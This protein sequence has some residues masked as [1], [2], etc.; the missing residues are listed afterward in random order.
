MSRK[1]P[2]TRVPYPRLD[3]P[4]RYL[5]SLPVRVRVAKSM[6]MA[7]RLDDLRARAANIRNQSVSELVGDGFTYA[8]IASLL[9]VSESRV[10]QYLK[11]SDSPRVHKTTEQRLT[12]AQAAQVLNSYNPFSGHKDLHLSNFGQS[13][14]ESIVAGDSATL[15]ELITTLYPLWNVEEET[16]DDLQHYRDTLVPSVA[17]LGIVLRGCT[18]PI[19]RAGLEPVQQSLLPGNTVTQ[20]FLE[21][22]RPES[23]EKSF[24]LFS[25]APIGRKEKKREASEREWFSSALLFEN[26]R[27]LAVL[28]RLREA[29]AK[30][31]FVETL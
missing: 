25:P 23:F 15:V 16:V 11:A 27:W 28:Q 26:P 31:C 1:S 22:Y 21:S 20:Q 2:L 12:K 19:E 14:E 17:R 4:E 13:V 30:E 9:S 29:M 8:E 6:A 7:E 24:A 3:N 5:E 18:I 10:K